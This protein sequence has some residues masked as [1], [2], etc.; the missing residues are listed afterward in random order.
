MEF[1]DIWTA[2]Y[3][4][5]F[6]FCT[7][8]YGFSEEDSRDIVQE[9]LLKVH[10]KRET[11]SGKYSFSTWIYRIARNSCIDFFRKHSTE[12]K[13]EYKA[14]EDPEPVI[15]RFPDRKQPSPEQELIDDELR[16]SI[17][18]FIDKLPTDDRELV[19]L[20]IYE[21]LT[22]REIS[23]VTGKP[24]GTVKYRFFNLRK[25]LQIYLGEIYEQEE[26]YN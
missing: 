2:Y 22:Y 6:V 19:Y 24:E 17:G 7:Q 8:S 15:L 1:E 9:I 5:L 13:S 16:K 21:D 23:G 12:R 11:Y 3:R 25:Q 4:R 20:R 26:T 14:A 18:R 10:R